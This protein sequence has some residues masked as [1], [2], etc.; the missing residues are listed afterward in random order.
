MP[1]VWSNIA[2]F[3]LIIAIL[4]LLFWRS[5]SKRRRSPVSAENSEMDGRFE[6]LVLNIF[7]VL[8]I[9]S[10]VFS[11]VALFGATS[12][13]AP[14]F[15]ILVAGGFFSYAVLSGLVVLI[16]NV[17]QIRRNTLK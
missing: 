6:V 13:N 15:A 12:D 9:I 17:V 11:L 3:A 14:I 16:Q 1:T 5:I 10:A 2:F 8:S 4:A 7:A